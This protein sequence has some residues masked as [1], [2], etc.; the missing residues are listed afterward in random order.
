MHFVEEIDQPRGVRGEDDL[1]CLNSLAGIGEADESIEEPA[2]PAG[3][4]PRLGFLDTKESG[5]ARA[6]NQ[7]E[8]TQSEEC[9]ITYSG[10]P[11]GCTRE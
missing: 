3:I 5:A 4:E 7:A 6:V 11:T 8:Q 1:G 10:L 9:P 2:K